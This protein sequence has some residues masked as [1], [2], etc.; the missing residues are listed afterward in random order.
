MSCTIVRPTLGQSYLFIGLMHTARTHTPLCIVWHARP[1]CDS[2][3]LAQH[4]GWHSQ[5]EG[6]S[7]G[8]LVNEFGEVRRAAM[9]RPFV[10]QSAGPQNTRE[11]AALHDSGCDKVAWIVVGL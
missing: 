10:I 8:P 1:C 5:Q 2:V 6:N 4:A 3:A 11:L 9:P 7:G